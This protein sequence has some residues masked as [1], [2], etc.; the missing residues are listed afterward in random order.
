MTIV[1]ATRLLK[2]SSNFLAAAA[3]AFSKT[4]GGG[5]IRRGSSLVSRVKVKP[6]CDQLTTGLPY[7]WM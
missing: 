5:D 2:M 6:D 1:S 3:P 4:R 7:A